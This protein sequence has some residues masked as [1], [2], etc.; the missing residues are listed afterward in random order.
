M[1][2]VCVY[3]ARRDAPKCDGGS[4]CA[5]S[6]S[7]YGKKKL[8]VFFMSTFWGSPCIWDVIK[9]RHE[10]SRL[11]FKRNFLLNMYLFLGESRH[12]R[13]VHNPTYFNNTF[14]DLGGF[15]IPATHVPRVGNKRLN[16]RSCINNRNIQ[17]HEF[18]D[19]NK[20]HFKRHNNRGIE[21]NYFLDDSIFYKLF[22]YIISGKMSKFYR[23][24]INNNNNYNNKICDTYFQNIE[25]IFFKCF[26]EK[27]IYFYNKHKQ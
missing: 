7:R 14:P 19:R 9:Y 5:H 13:F 21:R 3:D 16:N 6:H 18:S 27:C 17:F 26:I 11:I 2:L 8:S 25:N 1:L 15:Y 24:V 10:K 23:N 22:I 20:Q 12:W 4:D